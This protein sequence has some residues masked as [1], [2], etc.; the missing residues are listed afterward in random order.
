M[1]CSTPCCA[2]ELS[3]RL[4]DATVL[5]TLHDNFELILCRNPKLI[6][7]QSL[8]FF[9]EGFMFAFVQACS[10]CMWLRRAGADK[11]DTEGGS[12]VIS[13]GRGRGRLRHALVWAHAQGS[14]W[15]E[16]CQSPK[17]SQ[18]LPW[19]AHPFIL[20]SVSSPFPYSTSC[21]FCF[22]FQFLARMSTSSGQKAV[23]ILMIF[24]H[25]SSFL[26]AHF[27]KSCNVQQIL[28]WNVA[29][30]IHIFSSLCIFYKIWAWQHLGQNLAIV[31][32][33]Q[34]HWVEFWRW[35]AERTRTDAVPPGQ[36]EEPISAHDKYDCISNLLQP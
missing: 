33:I 32:Q 14:V 19:Y 27:T 7:L 36:T 31:N 17:R 3:S 2:A 24:V 29:K 4:L 22:H 1:E 8:H 13:H 9:Y 12:S 18:S 34:K 16:V 26:V 25:F 20:S 5:A 23:P 30:N 21:L 11:V 15:Q 35:I 10:C 6:V 28:Y